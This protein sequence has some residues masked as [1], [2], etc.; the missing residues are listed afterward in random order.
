MWLGEPVRRA[1]G[2]ANL[3]N[4]EAGVLLEARHQARVPAHSGLTLFLFLTGR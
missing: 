3:R 1:T 4:P 2:G